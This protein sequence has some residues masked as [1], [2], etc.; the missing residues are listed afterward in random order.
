MIQAIKDFFT[1][2]HTRLLIAFIAVFIGTTFPQ[3]QTL[4]NLIAY[5]LGATIVVTAGKA[6]LAAYVK[7]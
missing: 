7:K 6:F 2:S 5:Y 4:C 3:Y 1:P